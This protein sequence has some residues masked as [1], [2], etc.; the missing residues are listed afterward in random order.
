LLTWVFSSTDPAGRRLYV[1]VAQVVQNLLLSFPDRPVVPHPRFCLRDR[2]PFHK[3]VPVPLPDRSL[4]DIVLANIPFSHEVPP[5]YTAAPTVFFFFFLRQNLRWRPLRPPVLP[6][7]F[8]GISANVLRESGPPFQI[9]AFFSPPPRHRSRR[10]HINPYLTS[11]TSFDHPNGSCTLLTS[12]NPTPESAES[13]QTPLLDLIN[14]IFSAE[15]CHS[16]EKVVPTPPFIG[17]FSFQRFRL[18]PSG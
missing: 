2:G 13:R 17:H 4:C 10:P 1:L 12:R 15:R 14:I 5:I 18:L 16:F 8:F 9:R 3:S 11:R 7:L 6:R